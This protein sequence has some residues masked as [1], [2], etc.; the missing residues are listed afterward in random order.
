VLSLWPV[1]AHGRSAFPGGCAPGGRGRG[2]PPR[3]E[4]YDA[5]VTT[6]LV[7]RRRRR[8]SGDD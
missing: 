8:R 6:V 4:H 5:S 7:L 3:V 1:A 2:P